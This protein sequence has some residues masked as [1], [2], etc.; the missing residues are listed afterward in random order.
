MGRF[1][2]GQRV[3][4]VKGT[5]K[6]KGAG[7]YIA[8]CGRFSCRVN[9][10]NDAPHERTIRESSI[11]AFSPSPSSFRKGS[12]SGD[13]NDSNVKDSG[14]WSP[15]KTKAYEGKMKKTLL[16]ELHYLKVDVNERIERLEKEIKDLKIDE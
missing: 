4:I 12:V 15:K 10:D 2:N 1:H 16:R 5:Y 14:R 3:R 6:S 13:S 7:T 11:R 9:I 8:E